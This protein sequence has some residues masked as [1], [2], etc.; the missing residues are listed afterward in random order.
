MHNIQ[1]SQIATQVTF[2]FIKAADN[3]KAHANVRPRGLRPMPF[4]LLL[5]CLTAPLLIAGCGD[6]Q[7]HA[8]AGPDAAL[9]ERAPDTSDARF[10]GIR[11]LPDPLCLEEY[12]GTTGLLLPTPFDP[13][14]FSTV[15][16]GAE[17]PAGIARQL[18]D[19]VPLRGRRH[20][21]DGNHYYAVH[22]GRI[23][24]KANRETTGVDEPWRE[25]AL[26][27]CLAGQV[28]EISADGTVLLA[29]DGQRNIYTL[30]YV[31][32]AIGSGGWTRRW[33]PFFWTDLGGRIPDDVRDWATTHFT[34]ADDEYF[35]DSGGHPQT[36]AGIL[37]V[38]LLRGDGLRIT[39]LDPWLP[40]DESREVCGPA[41]GTTVM[42]GLSGSG[43]TAMVVTSEGDIFTR[44]YEFDVSGGN[45]V[46][47][48]YSWRD[49]HDV[50]QPKI[51]LP[52]PDWLPH[53]R[54]PGRITDRISLRK[55]PPGSEHRL[56][57]VEGMDSAGR[58]GYWEKDQAGGAWR[59]TATGAPLEGRLLPL[60][61]PHRGLPEDFAY[62]GR[63]D[64]HAARIADFNPYCSPATLALDI[65]DDTLALELHSSDGMRQER[66]AR[67]LDLYPR[68]YRA[69]V[70]VPEAT[71]A[72]RD[73]LPAGVRDFI[74]RHFGEGRVMETELY[75][76]L[77]SLR[78]AQ[79]CWKLTRAVDEPLR[80]LTQ[81]PLPDLGTLLSVLLAQQE[82]G[83]QPPL[84]LN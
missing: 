76:T 54:V 46:F 8:D 57:R 40:M 11:T 10:P 35:I 24:I 81:P 36:P 53:P 71:W 25:L 17:A 49:Q 26:P 60:D 55:L 59:F 83:R 75:A 39:Y 6:N 28:S 58:T 47:L 64:G 80:Q 12:L 1:A 9:A 13:A 62:S 70:M 16:G 15:T 82:D 44:L 77:D 22:E 52:A 66:R 65:G 63:I 32:G 4:R 43:S 37:N 31:N 42:A 14:R 72:R 67:G 18:P 41:R 78:L 29:L 7:R 21:H 73:R 45:A 23:Y 2:S 56:M 61:G 69:A 19:T 50:A 3:N 5:L 74:T 84:C 20:S 27:R 79:P 30:D 51:Q 68:H 38:F 34:E 33:G 48:D